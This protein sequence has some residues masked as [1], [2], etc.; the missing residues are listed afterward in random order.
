VIRLLIADDHLIARQGIRFLLEQHRDLDIVGEAGDGASVARL[1]GELQPD[2]VL[3]DLVMPGQDGVETIRELRSRAPRARVVVL[4][5]YHGDELIYGAVRAGALSYLLK[6]VDAGDLVQAVRAA[7]RGES[8]LH[9]RV[10]ARVLSGLR[11]DE[12]TEGLT[13]RELDVL[14]RLARGD[15]NRAIAAGLHIS[16]ETVKTH[17]S[18]LLSKLHVDS[19]TQAAL[20]ALR[21]NLVVPDDSSPER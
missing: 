13:R 4:T 17:V 18:N 10:A 14:T 1:A 11:G 7:A 5:S 15:S 16:E 3:L 19:R 9:P 8:T 2:V 12:L 6:D 20:Y 21:R